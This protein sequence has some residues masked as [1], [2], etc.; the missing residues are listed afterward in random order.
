ML[1]GLKRVNS[2]VKTHIKATDLWTL[3]EDAIFLKYV[4]NPRIACYHAMARDT[5]A[6]P[7]ELLAVKIGD[8]KMKKIGTKIIAEV[9]NVGQHGSKTKKVRT[10]PLINSIQYLKKLLAQHPQGENPDAYLFTNMEHSAQYRIAPI[11]E[12]TLA[13]IYR[14]L[15]LNH[16]PKL[17]QR[18]DVPPEDKTILREL[19]RKRWNPYIRRHTALTEKARLV[20]EYDLRQHAGWTKTSEMVEIYTH[21]LGH[22][23]SE[24][25]LLAYGI[26]VKS[27]EG[28][29]QRQILLESLICPHCS[30]PNKPN[31]KFCL[32]CGMTLSFDEYKATKEAAEKQQAEFEA[33]KARLDAIDICSKRTDEIVKK[34]LKREDYIKHYK[35]NNINR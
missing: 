34:M 32:A 26:D 3:E 29:Q 30:E 4:E 18:A 11:K 28:E 6:R 21:E 31:T 33:M 16:F 20:N 35:I 1:K 5:S 17:L 10:V 22:E 8:I 23:S 9:A 19:L 27:K 14:H 12:T 7:S 25:L 24:D 13:S 2:R 15:H